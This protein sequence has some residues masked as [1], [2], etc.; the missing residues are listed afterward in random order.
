MTMKEIF[1]QFAE[2][3]NI[4]MGELKLEPE[5]P[6]Q[7]YIRLDGENGSYEGHAMFLEEERMFIFYVILGV[8]VPEDK[9]EPVA[10]WL[11][12]LNYRLK[13]GQFYIEE[14]TGELTPTTCKTNSKWAL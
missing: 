4:P 8:R 2:E 5:A 12:N 14:N 10:A 13:A 7:L 6:D 1:A 3:N 11:L 9:R